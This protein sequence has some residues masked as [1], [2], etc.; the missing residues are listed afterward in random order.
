MWASIV[1]GTSRVEGT[2][3]GGP[4]TGQFLP[5]SVSGF[6]ERY[7]GLRAMGIVLACSVFLRIIL[8]VFNDVLVVGGMS[9]YWPVSGIVVGILLL[10][11]RSF[12]PWILLSFM[13]VDMDAEPGTIVGKTILVL[14]NTLEVLI[15]ALLL[16]ACTTLESWI[17]ERALLRRFIV[18]GLV[19]GPVSCSLP[20]SLYYSLVQQQA[21]WGFMLRW[22]VGDAMGMTLGLPLMLTLYS[23]ETYKL[24][25]RESIAE[26]AGL[27][28]LACAAS[29]VIFYHCS[30]PVGFMMLPILLLIAFRQGFSGSV[31]AANLLALI[32]CLATLHGKGPFYFGPYPE[33]ANG[34]VLLRVFL[35]VSMLICF[36][37]SLVLL[38]RRRFQRELSDASEQ[39]HLVTLRDGLTGIANRR[40][41]D[42]RVDEEWRRAARE[43]SSVSLLLIDVDQFK[44]FNDT[45]G[46]VEGDR[47]LCRVAEA[48][49]SVPRRITDLTARYGGEEFAVVMPNVNRAGTERVAELI[50]VAVASREMAHGG[51]LHGKVT[52]SI[53]CAIEFP[54][55]GT[56]PTSLIVAADQAL[57]AAKQR[58]RN[59]VE[60]SAE[61]RRRP[62]IYR[63]GGDAA[64]AKRAGIERVGGIAAGWAGRDGVGREEV[65]WGLRGWRDTA[66]LEIQLEE[67]VMA[68]ETVHIT[69]RPSGPLRVEGHIVLKDADGR[70]W[71]L[72]GKPAISL[73]RCGL[74]E[75]RPFC[76][77]AHARNGWVCETAPPENLT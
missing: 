24:F 26:A 25:R 70:E 64:Y 61:M 41:F 21:F 6:L 19:L 12:W 49:S 63:A 74:S 2:V 59:R 66:M 13:L 36:P 16:P 35:I 40:C 14:G 30:H 3:D 33:G 4:F 68:D 73:C 44:H 72:T 46:H 75:K 37:V 65:R 7:P 27:M 58:G 15:P 42:E 29:W 20:V 62:E 39:L 69:V 76:D 34:I 77:G 32:S 47:C 11:R 53:G 9:A 5:A 17:R 56:E 10:S 45:F 51:S 52:V 38:E 8:S 31:I 22:T 50:R 18:Y 28:G 60:S 1:S 23:R 48:I 57:Y 67:V 55:I 71:D 43:R 54:V